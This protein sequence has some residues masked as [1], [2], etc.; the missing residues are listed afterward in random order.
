M[1]LH[2]IFYVM[3]QQISINSSFSSLCVCVC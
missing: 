1:Q 2:L 3:E